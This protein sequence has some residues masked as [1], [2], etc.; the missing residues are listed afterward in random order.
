MLQFNR[1]TKNFKMMIL[2]RKLYVGNLH[3]T[4]NLMST[5]SVNLNYKL[6][7]TLQAK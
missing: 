6:L 3:E 2:F 1:N 5:C 7:K 4:D